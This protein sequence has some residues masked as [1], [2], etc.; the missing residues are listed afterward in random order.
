MAWALAVLLYC[1]FGLGGWFVVRWFQEP[2]LAQEEQ[3][4]P[5]EM[6]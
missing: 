4:W 1:M 3:V 6:E 5:E 2:D